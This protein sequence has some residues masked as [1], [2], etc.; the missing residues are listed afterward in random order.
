MFSWDKTL[1]FEGETGPYVQYTYARTCSLLKKA[2][3]EI[4]D[5]VD[6]SILTDKESFN[7][8]KKLEGFKAAVLGSHDKYEPFYV[9]RYVVGLAQEFNRFYHECPII[10]MM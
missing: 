8:I 7:V 3:I 2:D 4:D 6:F 5:N 9:T 1:S 10:L